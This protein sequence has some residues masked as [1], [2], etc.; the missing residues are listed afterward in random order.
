MIAIH[1]VIFHNIVLVI[2][3]HVVVIV[4]YV[5][6]IMRFVV[7]N[8]NH[9]NVNVVGNSVNV[10][11]G[12]DSDR[13]VALIKRIGF[14]FKSKLNEKFSVDEMF[15]NLKTTACQKRFKSRFIDRFD[16]SITRFDQAFLN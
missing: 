14:V 11:H 7:V 2:V 3:N 4:I 13:I 6:V 16:I 10:N 1:G 8:A 5:V 12:D 9:A 15:L